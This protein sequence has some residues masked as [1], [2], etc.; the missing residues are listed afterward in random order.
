[1]RRLFLT[2]IVSLVLLSTAHANDEISVTPTNLDTMLYSF[3]VSTNA[4]HTGVAFHV[5]ITHKR[6]DIYP[7]SIADVGT[8]AYT[9]ITNSTARPSPQPAKAASFER[10]KPAIPVALKKEKR[11]WTA[12]FTAS[13]EL[14]KNTNACFVFSVFAQDPKNGNKAAPADLYEL[15]LQDFAKP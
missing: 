4:T 5:T 6:F 15:R 1:M 9:E 13:H 3:T 11:I 14:L 10:L 2:V 8:I 12:E 7:D